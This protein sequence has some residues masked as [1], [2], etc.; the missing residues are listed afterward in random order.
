MLL[1]G[2]D[3]KLAG[4]LTLIISP[5]TMLT[6]FARYSRDGSFTV[7]REQARFCFSMAL[8]SITGAF[9]C[10][11]LPASVHSPL[12]LPLPAAILVLSAWKMWRHA[13]Q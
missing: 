8:G 2:V 12:L 4:S 7:I 3:V 6:S 11:Q 13:K 5:P 10:A 9:P 1:Y